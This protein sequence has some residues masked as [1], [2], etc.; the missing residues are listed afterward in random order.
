MTTPVAP[1]V[2]QQQFNAGDS[3]ETPQPPLLPPAGPG[4]QLQYG[5][6]RIPGRKPQMTHTEKALIQ[7]A[8]APVE[9][10]EEA[11]DDFKSRLGQVEGELN[12]AANDTVGEAE[13]AQGRIDAHQKAK[14]L[15]L[16]KLQTAMDMFEK[17]KLVDPW[18]RKSTG[19]KILM[20]LGATLGGFGAGMSRTP[21]LALNYIEGQLEQDL[22]IQKANKAAEA[23]GID[24]RMRALDQV[25]KLFDSTEQAR[26]VKRALKWRGVELM[27]QKLEAGAKTQEQLVTLEQLKHG[28]RTKSLEAQYTY[29]QVA[30]RRAG[31][32][33]IHY[34]YNPE[35]GIKMPFRS[36]EAADKYMRGVKGEARADRE[37]QIK[38]Q[39]ANLNAYKAAHE[40]TGG[41]A[42]IPGVE[43]RGVTKGDREKAQPLIAAH[44]GAE[45][46]L[47]ALIAFREKHGWLKSFADSEEATLLAHQYTVAANKVAE[48]GALSKDDAKFLRPPNLNNQGMSL[49]RDAIIDQ[50]KSV[51]ENMRGIVGAKIE[52]YGYKLPKTKEEAGGDIKTFKRQ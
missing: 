26:A 28:A 12:Q 6:A 29:E 39:G 2:P 20:T 41:G 34:V 47:D 33:V 1:H 44:K 8:A 11:A 32:S 46:A 23:E 40:A 50:L 7:E 22:N 38:E 51:K 48:L 10:A 52:T 15:E 14:E 16:N 31:G 49:S 27:I 21:N 30:Q 3:Y 45:K 5:V 35:T 24:K 17:N 43:G 25:D 18:E 13:A 4:P 36:S 19:Q 42:P 9:Y 37:L